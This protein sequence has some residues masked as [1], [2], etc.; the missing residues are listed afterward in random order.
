M[1]KKLTFTLVCLF[2]FSVNSYSQWNGINT[3]S[4]KAVIGLNS[5]SFSF[6]KKFT[7]YNNDNKYGIYSTLSWG[8]NEETGRY[9]IYSKTYNL[10]DW[11]L[12]TEG[13]IG[14]QGNI[15]VINSS[16]NNK[17]IHYL[18]WS[19]GDFSYNI[20]S[21]DGNG[22]LLNGRKLQLLRDGSMV[23][24][25]DES[26]TRAIVVKKHGIA[27]FQVMGNGNVLAREI[28]VSLEEFPDYVFGEDY[29][30]M[31]LKD[32]KIFINKY[33]HLPNIPSE[34]E[35]VANGMNLGDMQ[36]RQMEKLEEMTLY[37]LELNERLLMLEEE[38]KRLQ[39]EFKRS[40]FS[41][42]E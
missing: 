20:G 38:N 31:S 37:I 34:S 29:D 39:K 7:V 17:W 8:G 11:A 4:N 9:S 16:I 32:L 18:G 2:L 12:Y 28:K 42:K 22:N 14:V 41:I 23:K 6:D 13:K 26:E 33:N 27:E 19:A 21:Y 35:I 25:V 40:S 5:L 3:T 24:H 36:S 1:K 15:E 10:N 30:L